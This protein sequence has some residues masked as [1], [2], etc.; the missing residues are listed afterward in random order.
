VIA[1]MGDWDPGTIAG[2]CLVASIPM[3]LW[4]LR[5]QVG[6]PYNNDSTN[7][8]EVPN[9][10]GGVPILGNAL[11]YKESP[12]GCIRDQ[13]KMTGSKVFR[14][15]MAGRRMIVIGSDRVAM[16]QAATQPTSVFSSRRAVAEIGFEYTLG[17][18]NVYQGT[19]WHKSI[20]KNRV[21]G[22]NFQKKF[23][24][25]IYTALDNALQQELNQNSKNEM[26][27][28]DFV[29]FPDLFKLVRRCFLRAILDAFVS[30]RLLEEEPALLEELMIFQDMVEDS[31][32]KAAILP[33]VL[34]LPAC[35]WRTQKARGVLV[36]R[37]SRII[38]SIWETKYKSS[39]G[40][41]MQT[42]VEDKTPPEDAA[43]HI[44]G[45]VF[46]AHKNPAIG[47]SQCLC[48]IVSE[49]SNTQQ[50]EARAEAQKLC[51][52]LVPSQAGKPTLMKALLEAKT[53]RSSVLETL[54]LTAHTLGALRYVE[55]SVQLKTTGGETYHIPQG[56]TVAIA[57][58]SMHVESSIWGNDA[59]KFSIQ[60]NE[61]KSDEREDLGIPVDRYKFT[62][63]SNGVHKC[64]G[65]KIALAM[66]E[67]LVALLLV[68]GAQI[69]G[70]LP[71]ISFERATLAQRDG[72]VPVQV[73]SLRF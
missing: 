72:P 18:I 60:R 49:L 50:E 34:A 37:L 33:R 3:S 43:D 19:D 16:K 67:M 73:N 25:S 48:F 31:T 68:Q 61:W 10:R 12:T 52:Y 62:A 58:H 23:L 5:K 41:W 32:A 71:P 6:Q 56:E 63:F 26:D 17:P 39:L 65:E 11:Q 9:A 38:S 44:I 51:N 20:L 8:T 30:P 40:P 54:R 70:E 7:C 28:D 2:L 35:L 14:I 21:M 13:E 1:T 47:T 45:L 46:S 66:M 24:P 36:N 57:H 27:K 59:E 4:I 55:K 64:P 53:L 69:V 42:Y 29:E 22:E 15:N